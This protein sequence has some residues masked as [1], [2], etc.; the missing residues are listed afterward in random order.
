MECVKQGVPMI[1]WPM[2]AEQRMNATMLSD[3]VGVAVKMPVVGEGGETVVVGRKAIERV[4]RV[5]LEGEEG[6][7]LRTRAKELE[8][9]GMETL[10]CEG[11]SNQTLARVVESWKL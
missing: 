2:Y 6:M 1:A 9:S 3:E 5:V 4:V 11:S 8:V 7:R 10:G